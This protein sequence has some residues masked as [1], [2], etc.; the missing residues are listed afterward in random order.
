MVTG[1]PYDRSVTSSPRIRHRR[2]VRP[3]LLA[4]MVVAIVLGV[5]GMHG[6]DGHGVS[7]QGPMAH[8][9]DA[10]TSTAP[11]MAGHDTALGAAVTSND[12]HPAGDGMG[13]TV[14]VCVAML[15]GAAMV[16]LA[17]LVRRGRLPKVW[18]VLEP[19]GRVRRVV[20]VVLRSGTGPPAVWRFSVIRC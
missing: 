5:L 20:P 7:L 15:A 12:V 9:A 16:L 18:A 14:M 11:A 6:I 2:R 10:D 1:D 13:G 3:G 8:A 19:A 17:V 4:T